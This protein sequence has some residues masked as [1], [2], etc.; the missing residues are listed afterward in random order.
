M[1]REEAR[2][3]GDLRYL[4]PFFVSK[5]RDQT[6]VPSS[7]KISFNS[8][9]SIFVEDFERQVLWDFSVLPPILGGQK[10]ISLPSEKAIKYVTIMAPAKTTK[11]MTR[12]VVATGLSFSHL[13][14]SAMCSPLHNAA[15]NCVKVHDFDMKIILPPFDPPEPPNCITGNVTKGSIV[16]S[17]KMLLS[18]RQKSQSEEPHDEPEKQARTVGSGATQIPESGQ[19]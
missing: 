17:G 18:D 15:H 7:L 19:G 6:T 9:S 13:K 16:A 11:T 8:F 5:E 1:I 4:L 12:V 2:A 10:E 3:S 14:S